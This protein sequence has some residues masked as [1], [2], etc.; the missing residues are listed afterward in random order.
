MIFIHILG[1]P[2]KYLTVMWPIP[3]PCCSSF[4]NTFKIFILEIVL[5][6]FDF[7]TCNNTTKNAI[8]FTPSLI[9]EKKIR[10]RDHCNQ[11]FSFW[12]HDYQT[13]PTYF[14]VLFAI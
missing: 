3:D 14:H 8:M 5:D 13:T 1:F 11:F 12:E 6:S 9:L 7:N 4:E 2:P 10:K